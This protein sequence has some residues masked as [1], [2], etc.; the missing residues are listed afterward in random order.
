MKMG[1]AINNAK[2]KNTGIFLAICLLIP[3]ASISWADDVAVSNTIKGKAD[4]APKFIYLTF[5]DG[6]LKGSNDVSEAVELEKIKINVFVVGSHLK[7]GPRMRGYFELYTKNP[8]I[9]I[10]NHSYSH[11]HDSYSLFYSKPELAYDDFLYNADI[12][13]LKNKLARLPGRNMWRLKNRSIDDVKS[14]SKTAD[15]LYSK[16]YTVF[17]WDLEWRHDRITAGPVQTVE[18][19]VYLIDTMFAKK[20]TVTENH[21]VI[22]CHDEM[23]MT[24]W[25]ESKL[26]ELIEKLIASGNFRFEHLSNYPQ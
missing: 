10:G 7:A 16:G 22:L 5:D 24:S 6:P 25:E 21:I 18:D 26:K 20:K 1:I 19:M 4:S 8:Y 17:G 9:E 3:F 15:L 12:L 2:I 23:F 11:A 14:G 13:K